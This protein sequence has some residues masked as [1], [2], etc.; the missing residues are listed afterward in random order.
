MTTYADMLFHLGG[1]PVGL[2]IPFSKTS[3]YWFVDPT[4][5]TAGGSGSF[6]DP[7]NK[8]SI[9]ES[10]C[11]A[12]RHDC[13]IYISG[14]TGATEEATLTWDK[15]YTHLLGIGAPTMV[16][17]RARIHNETETGVTPLMAIE[18]TGCIFKNFYIFQG[19]NEAVANINVHLTGGRNYFE[20]VHFAGGGHT[21][22]AINGGASLL[23]D[24]AEENT[25]EG[26]TIGVDTID[27]ATGMVALAFDGK[28]QRN[29]IRNSKIQLYAG[30]IDCAFVEV[31]DGTGVDR[32]NSFENVKF[33]N[34]NQSSY[35]IA[36]AFLIPSVDASHRRLM[37]DSLCT[38]L[39]VTT[40]D[41]S[42][43]GL[44]FGNLDAIS[45]ADLS[46]VSV[47]LKT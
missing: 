37:I 31:V 16:A 7:V 11:V 32:W 35:E 36:S 30:H 14:S 29:T 4:Q 15:N 6:G 42:D 44:L 38:F 12:N 34:P 40:L 13:V 19:V 18:A 22:Q 1:L 20:N 3:H 21:A 10:F 27:A 43:R 45:G 23:M 17:Q 2:G 5:G 24:G 46:G 47:E 39:G 8:V 41:A 28:S 26:C 25:L 33:I 9:A